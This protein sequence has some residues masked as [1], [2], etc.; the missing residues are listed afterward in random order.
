MTKRGIQAHRSPAVPAALH[1][2][3]SHP[4]SLPVLTAYNLYLPIIQPP[5][6]TTTMFPIDDFV[7]LTFTANEILEQPTVVFKSGGSVVHN[8]GNIIY[9]FSNN[10]TTWTAKYAPHSS[11][12]EGNVT[13]TLDFNDRAG[14]DATQVTS[15]TDSSAVEV[16]L[17]HPEL[18]ATPSIISNNST[19]TLAKAGDTI[20]LTFVT[21]EETQCRR[22]FRLQS[23]IDP[24]HCRCRPHQYLRTVRD[25]RARLRP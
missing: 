9:A 2:T 20:T 11:D 7:I 19:N 6:R 8:R 4:Q 21:D 10:K 5:S 23:S 14:N 25:G 22:Y 15:T 17:D 12:S 18:T 13:F 16:D 3:R 1:L 24:H